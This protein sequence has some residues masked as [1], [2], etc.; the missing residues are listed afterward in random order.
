MIGDRFGLTPLAA[1]AKSG[2]T[3]CVA[4]LIRHFSPDDDSRLGE[5]GATALDMAA[6]SGQ[7]DCYDRLIKEGYR[8]SVY[9][10][11]TIDR[12]GLT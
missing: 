4:L 9:Y 12:D 2:K 11:N 7:G 3:T 5:F 6:R 1:A 8:H 10:L